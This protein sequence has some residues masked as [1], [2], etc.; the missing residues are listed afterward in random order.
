[1]SLEHLPPDVEQG[2]EMF[3]GRHH[4]SHD[5][6]I[7]RLLESGLEHEQSMAKIN[8]LSGMPMTD[9][10]ARVVDDAVSIAMD[11]RRQRSERMS[12]G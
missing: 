5:E 9:E 11:A 12:R 1:M 8:G 7:V 3:A 4:I 10:D 6:A 2:V